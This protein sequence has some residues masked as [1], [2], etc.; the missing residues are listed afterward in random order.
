MEEQFAPTE[1]AT[2]SRRAIAIV[3]AILV[4]GLIAWY[5]LAL[6]QDFTLLYRDLRPAQAAAIVA[7]LEEDGVAYRLEADGADILTPA[8]E[9]DALRL[10]L[11][12]SGGP[13]SGLD[14]FELFN[15]S[16][17][18]LT[19]FAQ[20]IRYQRAI[21]GELARTIM[22]M[23]GVA[24]ARV[25]VSM[26][27][28]TLF[29]GER[30]NAEAAV[31][32]VMQ[33]GE[34]ATADR[35]EGVQR[36]V[37]AA[38]ADLAATDVVV[39]SGRGEVISSRVTV[40]HTVAAPIADSAS[41]SPSLD[42][43]SEVMRLAVP[44]RRFDIRVEDIPGALAGAADGETDSSARRLIT[45]ATESSL[46]PDERERVRAEFLRADLIDGSSR[47]L[48][49]F[50]VEPLAPDVYAPTPDIDTAV[51]A[52]SAGPETRRAPFFPAWL[53]VIGALL[54]IAALVGALIWRR[55][56]TPTLSFEQQKL[57]AA[58]LRARL[59]AQGVEA[60]DGR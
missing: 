55:A 57:I 40:S 13:L 36:L 16:D 22:T 38:V 50:R 3:V 33:P 20:K 10:R 59:E 27:E 9:T 56:T 24:E 43:I 23:Q 31:T 58:R 25:H 54:A 60:F 17:M 52:A 15:E 42:Y 47:Q 29:R 45:I 2:I 32:L 39:L 48:L 37:A 1:Q 41:T 14:G 46:S 34:Q 21:Q 26:P 18:G 7:A 12:S 6:R 8:R 49:A 35:I 53:V 28:R 11:A 19:D 4:A 5:F 44:N 51:V 30:R